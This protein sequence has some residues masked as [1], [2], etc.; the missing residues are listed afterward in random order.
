MFHFNSFSI[1]S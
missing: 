1:C